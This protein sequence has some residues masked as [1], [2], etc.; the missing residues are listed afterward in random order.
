VESTTTTAA[1][2]AVGATT[3]RRNLGYVRLL[4]NDTV[5]ES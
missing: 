2:S 5:G 4:G 1:A 3:V